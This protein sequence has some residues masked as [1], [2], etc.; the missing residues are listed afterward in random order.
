MLEQVAKDKAKFLARS[1]AAYKSKR[2][3]FHL[4]NDRYETSLTLKVDREKGV[5][6]DKGHETT[7]MQGDG[8]AENVSVGQRQLGRIKG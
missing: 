8:D 5:I 1:Y 3:R 6:S 4:S 7:G 2:Y